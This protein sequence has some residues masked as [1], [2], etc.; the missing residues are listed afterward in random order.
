MP[1]RKRLTTSQYTRRVMP[2]FPRSYVRPSGSIARG[3]R[4]QQ[5]ASLVGLEKKYIDYEITNTAMTGNWA[6]YEDATADCISAVAQGDGES[7][8]DG[9]N[10][11]IT[12]VHVKGE[13]YI[14]A[15][16]A[17][18]APEDDAK[19]RVC[20]VLDKQTNGAQLVATTVMDGSLA[21]DWLAFRNMQYTKRFTVLGDKT[22]VMRPN[23]LN[24][25]AVNSFANGGSRSHTFSFNV[26][27]PKGLKVETTSTS[28]VIANIMNNSL[29]IIAVTSDTTATLNYHS[30]VRFVG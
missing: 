26:N 19:V 13:V 22:L 12:S 3:R 11:V 23:I 1:K 17:S 21:N 30:R 16:E 2:F 20:L 9:K 8:R 15:A 14:P 18:A 27:F 5:I 29:H 10:Y 28:A 25:G 6:T 7:N 24:E 4:R